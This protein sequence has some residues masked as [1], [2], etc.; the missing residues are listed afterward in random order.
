MQCAICLYRA[1][2]GVAGH[3]SRCCPLGKTECRH[4]LH[5]EKPFYLAGPCVNVGCVHN[6]RCLRCHSI[7]HTMYTLKLTA[8]RWRVT[9][10]GR[11]VPVTGH[12]QPPVKASDFM[13]P[14]ATDSLV[15]RVVADVHERANSGAD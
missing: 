13:C 4:Q 14:L 1:P 12:M 5:E 6:Q 9:M 11:A 10:D 2:H 7:G 15:R 3:P 8:T